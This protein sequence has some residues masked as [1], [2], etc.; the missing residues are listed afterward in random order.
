[1]MASRAL[2]YAANPITSKRH[3]F[4]TLMALFELYIGKNGDSRFRPVAA[5]GQTILA[6]EGYKTKAAA[7]NGIPSV[8]R[9]AGRNDAFQT[10]TGK[11]G[12]HY[13]NLKATNGQVI[14]VSQGYADESGCANGMESVM[15][16]A[17]A[18]VDDQT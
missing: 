12:K 3:L 7:E 15:K 13:F 11:N 2:L 9:N 10:F 14:G 8:S 1:M 17:G 6:S 4:P 18:E 5:N 16:N